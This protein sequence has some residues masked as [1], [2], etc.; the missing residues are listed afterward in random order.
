MRQHDQKRRGGEGRVGDNDCGSSR[1]AFT[2]PRM[3]M[4][5]DGSAGWA[6]CN[7]M[8]AAERRRRRRSTSLV[9]F[10]VIPKH[11]YEGKG[12]DLPM[13]QYVGRT[14]TTM[15][16]TTTV[17]KHPTKWSC[18]SRKYKCR[19]RTMKCTCEYCKV[20][21]VFHHYSY[22]L[23]HHFPNIVVLILTS[24]HTPLPTF[25]Q[26]ANAV[27]HLVRASSP[28]QPSPSCTSFCCTAGECRRT[29]NADSELF[30]FWCFWCC[31]CS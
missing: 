9:S 3:T 7:R 2:T 11:T 8:C 4:A 19:G 1:R 25:L 16:T 22:Y 6:E 18:I 10:R 28:L 31:R 30:C 12:K 15:T 17:K 21:H 20:G 23:L 26:R 24:A 13:Q 14:T 5:E 29:I 27:I